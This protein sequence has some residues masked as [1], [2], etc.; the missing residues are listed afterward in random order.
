ML[1]EDYYD[2]LD[3]WA[4]ST[5]VSRMSQL[6]SFGP[7]DEIADAIDTIGFD[8]KKGATR[9]LK[10]AIAA[11]VKFTGSQLSDFFITCDEAVVNRAVQASS[12]GFTEDDLDV[13]YGY[14]EEKVLYDIAKKQKIPIP[15]YLEDYEESLE[16]DSDGNSG[17]SMTPEE[18]IA[19]YDYILDCLQ[20][21]HGLLKKAYQFSLIDT[22][23]RK[24]SATVAK[25]TRIA[26]G[27]S[28]SSAA[29]ESWNSLDLPS[30]DRQALR[31]IWP[32]ISNSTMSQNYLFE[33]F[34]TNLIVKREIRK[35]I[36]NIETAYDQV[37]KLRSRR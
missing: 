21:A 25:Y 24:R 26:D 28:Y 10:K 22:N 14:C 11:G 33:G 32:N 4:T 20:N 9:L 19:E 35:V 15:E 12:D 3:D 1:W 13:L 31:G 5:A 30:Q 2:K 7:P 36:R 17:R 29:L 8:D 37:R 34:F 27:Q 18:R 23:R 16:G 6:E